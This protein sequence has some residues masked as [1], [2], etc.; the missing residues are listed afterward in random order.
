M[1]RGRLEA[2][3]EVAEMRGDPSLVSDIPLIERW[4]GHIASQVPADLLALGTMIAARGQALHG[5][6]E[7]A[8]ELAA[9]AEESSA[10]EPAS[11]PGRW[12]DFDAPSMVCD[13]IR[14]ELV[15]MAVTLPVPRSVP[16]RA[17]R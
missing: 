1:L 3:V 13:R 8:L 6:F 9:Q 7:A 5:R 15:R 17:A 4:L 11:R 12:A 14:L 10:Q 2:L 16:G